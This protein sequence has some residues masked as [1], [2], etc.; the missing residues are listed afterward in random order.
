MSAIALFDFTALN[1]QNFLQAYSEQLF[2]VLKG[3]EFT[4]TDHVADVSF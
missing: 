4:T 2:A 1:P 3:L